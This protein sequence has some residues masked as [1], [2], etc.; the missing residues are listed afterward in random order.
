MPPHRQ[1][2]LWMTAAAVAFAAIQLGWRLWLL[3][4]GTPA[5]GVVDVA[6]DSCRSRH[7]ANCF[8]GRAIVDP[9]VRGHRYRHSKIRG[10]RFYTVGE[11]VPMRV[12]PDERMY[13]AAVYTP[14]DWVLG[15]IR[16]AAVAALWLFAALMPARRKALWIAPC[17]LSL[18]LLFG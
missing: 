7:R 3:Q 13:L 15:P 10:G 9:Q 6:A 11:R 16:S 17:V 14:V 12:H 18:F 5:I 2:L 1:V 4:A 8:L